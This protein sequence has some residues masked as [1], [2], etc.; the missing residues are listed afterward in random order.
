MMKS[1]SAQ[2]KKGIIMII[3]LIIELLRHLEE[4]APR[5]VVLQLHIVHFY[6]VQPPFRM[7][8]KW[9]WAWREQQQQQVKGPVKTCKRTN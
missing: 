1:L 3:E 5:P 6:Q 9:R 7:T 8:A 2:W 4:P